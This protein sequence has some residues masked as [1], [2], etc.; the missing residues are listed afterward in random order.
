MGLLIIQ[1]IIVIIL[2]V[3]IIYMIRQNIALSYEKR[4][5][6]YSIDSLKSK[7]MS[8]SDKLFLKYKIGRAHV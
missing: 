2:L 8:L 1:I 3:I 5:S 7:E 6:N 4:I